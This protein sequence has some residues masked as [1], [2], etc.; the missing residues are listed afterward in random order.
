MLDRIKASLP[1]LAPAEQRVAKLVLG[2]PRAFANLP[3]SELAERHLPTPMRDL[4]MAP[5]AHDTPDELAQPSIRDWTKGE[6]EPVP[7]KTMSHLV[8]VERDYVNLYNRFISL[9]PLARKNGMGAHGVKYAIEDL[10]DEV[11]NSQTNVIEEWNGERYPS[12][13]RAEEAANMILL[14]ALPFI[15]RRRERRLLR[16]PVAVLAAALT[17]FFAVAS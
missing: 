14:F 3:V 16:R 4:V 7:G 10:Y 15:D 5:L 1:S 6:C 8:L 13:R 12:L 9:G 11:V 17:A 2:D